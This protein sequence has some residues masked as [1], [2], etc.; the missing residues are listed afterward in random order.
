MSVV[1]LDDMGT[2]VKFV[3]HSPSEDVEGWRK[4]NLNEPS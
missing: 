4:I 3:E 1:T 2:Y